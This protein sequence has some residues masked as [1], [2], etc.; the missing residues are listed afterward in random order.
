M[1]KR[2]KSD[3]S[4]G[5]LFNAPLPTTPTTP[6]RQS[7]SKDPLMTG[8]PVQDKRD[9]PNNIYDR[10]FT[11]KDFGVLK[12]VKI[13]ASQEDRLLYVLEGKN[14]AN[15]LLKVE[16]WGELA[17]RFLEVFTRCWGEGLK[18]FEILIADDIPETDCT[19]LYLKPTAPLSPYDSKYTTV[20]KLSTK[21]KG[22]GPVSTR[23]SAHTFPKPVA[24]KENTFFLA[25]GQTPLPHPDTWWDEPEPFDIESLFKVTDMTVPDNK[26]QKK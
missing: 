21:A 9:D 7:S 1:S 26:K 18:L 12:T 15:H 19:T 16:I 8:T 22:K 6:P 24:W 14:A 20:Y 25:D 5:N 11:I 3:S 13:A 2:S 23:L 17:I 4:T 10:F